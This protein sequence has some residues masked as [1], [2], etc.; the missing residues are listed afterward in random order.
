MDIARTTLDANRRASFRLMEVGVVA[1]ASTLRVTFRIHLK[2]RGVGGL[3]R[4]V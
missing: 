4:V 1:D 2:N 3:K